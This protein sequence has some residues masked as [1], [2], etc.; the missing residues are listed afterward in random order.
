MEYYITDK[1]GVIN[2]VLQRIETQ[3]IKKL[4]EDFEPNITD[5]Y[6]EIIEHKEGGLYAIPI[7]DLNWFGDIK[8]LINAEEMGAFQ[9]NIDGWF[10]DI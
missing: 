4:Y 1:Y 8:A 5:K 3:V 2:S 9:D 10:E 6:A 7:M